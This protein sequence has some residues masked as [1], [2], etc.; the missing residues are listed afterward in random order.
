[1]K[2]MNAESIAN[3]FT[4]LVQFFFQTANPIQIDHH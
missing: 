3:L 4:Q 2:T 1:M